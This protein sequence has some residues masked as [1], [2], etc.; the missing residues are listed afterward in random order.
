MRL[1]LEAARASKFLAFDADGEPIAS[2]GVSDVPVSSFWEGIVDDT[3]AGESLTTLG[4]SVYIQTLIDDANAAAARV[5]LEVQKNN[6]VADVSLAS[7]N[8]SESLPATPA[9]GDEYFLSWSGGDG[10]YKYTITPDGSDTINGAAS[11]I[12]SGDGRCTLVVTASGV[13]TIKDYLSTVDTGW[14]ANSDWTDADLTITHNL[15]ANLREVECTMLIS[16]TGADSDSFV[17]NDVV[18]EAGVTTS[19]GTTYFQVDVNSYKIQTGLNGIFF[20]RDSDGNVTLI[21]AQSWNYRVI[22]K[23]VG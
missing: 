21:A 10:T 14:I 3:T 7:G 15:N 9:I 1:P 5:T 11:L 12:G 16:P 23:K 17:I 22:T 2:G 6:L 4:F 20:L 13:W 8:Q 19:A 18:Y